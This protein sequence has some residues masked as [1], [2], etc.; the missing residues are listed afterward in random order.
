MLVKRLT[1]TI[2]TL[3]FSVCALLAAGV[4]AAGAEY[5][6]FRAN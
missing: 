4:F 6:S 1:P 2:S 3:I 5:S